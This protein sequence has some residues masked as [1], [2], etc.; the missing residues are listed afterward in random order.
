[1]MDI[2]LI[3]KQLDEYY[4]HHDL[5]GAYAFMIKHI[6]QAISYHQDDVLLFLL[7]ELIGYYRAV[8]LFDEGETIIHKVLA[9]LEMLGIQDSLDGAT[10]YLNIATFYRAKGD[11]PLALEY[12]NK[13]EK[14]YQYYLN[15]LDER[16]C[17]FYNNISLLYQEMGDYSRALQLSYQALNIVLKLP[18]C[19]SEQAITYTNLAHIYLALNDLNHAKECLTHALNLFDQEDSHYFSVLSALAHL[20]YL[21]HDYEKS[22]SY[23]DQAIEG[24][25][26]IYGCNKDYYICM[27]NKEKVLHEMKKYSGLELSKQY[28]LTYGK[29]MLEMYF[30]DYLP[31]MAIGLCGFGSDCLGYDDFISQDHDF[32]PGFCIWL[33]RSI[34][35]QIGEQLQL[36]YNQ[37]PQE[38][39]GYHRQES[40]HGQGRVGVFCIEDFFYQFIQNLP[41]SLDD[42]L[43]KDDQNL[44]CC[45]NGEIFDDYFGEVTMIRERLSYY[46]EDIRLK[47][48]AKNIAIMAQSGQYNYARCLT[49][50]DFVAASLCFN[51]FLEALLNVIYLAN[52]KYK[53]YY[54]WSY[55]GL[56]DCQVLK[57]VYPLIQQ[58]VEL[59]LYHDSWKDNQLQI[60]IKDPRIVL[61]E[62][63]CSLVVTELK[64]QGLTSLDDDFLDVHAYEIMKHIQNSYIRNKHVMEG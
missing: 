14:I 6:E 23:Y 26:N 61:I 33:P 53:P 38:F 24:I 43:K 16:Y 35:A 47:K 29:K 15:P 55:Y 22:L 59:P 37:L 7:N 18:H 60:N 25:K 19:Q 58:L 50:Q 8:S 63:I 46:P 4:V 52:K 10:T 27:Q 28:Y 42:W 45:V 20:Y 57:N 32:G 56:K 3:Q 48:L 9:I 12:Y 17:G 39:M 30:K 41:I 31:Y 62:R 1:M 40:A 11:Y 21:K 34:Y 64:N 5:D 49:R 51:E 44:L 13:T 36:A 2:C 54:K